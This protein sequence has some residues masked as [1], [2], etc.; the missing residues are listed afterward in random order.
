[1]GRRI[2][3]QLRVS[4]GQCSDRG[5]KDVNQDFY[6]AI[7]PSQPLLGSKGVAVVLADGISSSLVSRIA[8]EAAVK[9][10]LEDYYC[11]SE[12]WSVKTSAQRV[13]A[14]A[15]SWLFAQTRR[16]AHPYDRDKGYVCTLSAVVIKSATA[17]IFHI[18]D[19]RVYRVSG[20][21]LEQLTEDHRVV[22][23]SEQS[24]LGRALGVNPQVE[25]DYLDVPVGIGDVLLLATDGVHEYVDPKVMCRTIEEC[26]GDLDSAADAIVREAHRQGS[27]DNTTVQ[28][29]RIDEVPDGE[30]GEVIGELHELPLP[31][32]LDPGVVFEGYRIVRELHASSRSHVYLT[33]DLDS[34][35]PI[36]L[37]VPSID[38]R[39]DAAY[40]KHFMLE[41]WVLRRVNNPH[42]LRSAGRNG[43]R[44]YLC[45]VTEYVEGQ[46]LSQWMIDHPNPDLETVR[47]IVEQIAKGLQALHRMEML[48]Q[49]LRPDNIIIDKTGTVKIIDFG[50]VSIA[51]VSEA[52]PAADRYEVLGT[53]QYTA[54]EYFLSEGGTTRS[55]LF[56]LGVIAYQLLTGRLPYDAQVA[57]IKSK[58]DQKR[59]RYRAAA[60]EERGIPIWIDG[61]L[62]RAVHPNPEKR[63]EELSEF[64]FDLR[65]PNRAYIESGS[66]PL[67]ERDPLLFWKALSAVLAMIVLA[68][69]VQ[70]ARH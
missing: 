35:K 3:R 9:T 2:P 24:Y 31:P 49:D 23:S 43:R 57:R 22:L 15:N 61:A 19:S 21:S 13:I 44:N 58:S 55:D 64:M 16:G 46:S 28:I 10:F 40:L 30:A 25:I 45:T 27:S 54:P 39:G 38:L 12:T 68:L 6:G 48:H 34:G 14:A 36:A 33:T 42:L 47:D 66:K 26:A 51:G 8:S 37:K 59:L 52:A 1:L 4:I 41:E 63:Y 11:T 18:G 17:H 32:L 7:I 62:R 69:V 60:G 70:M 20:G 67:L 56:S 50:S 5:R 53:L 29:V 65:N